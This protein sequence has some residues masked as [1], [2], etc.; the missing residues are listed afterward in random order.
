M[1][2]EYDA[3][4]FV[5][6]P[7]HERIQRRVNF[8]SVGVSPLDEI[9]EEIERFVPFHAFPFFEERRVSAAIQHMSRD[10]TYIDYGVGEP[11]RLN[12]CQIKIDRIFV[13]EALEIGRGIEP[14]QFRSLRFYFRFRI[15]L[16][17]LTSHGEQRA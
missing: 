2:A 13:V 3:G 8:Q 9:A 4:I 7:G 15:C 12:L 14:H 10:G 5:V 16:L 11:E 1:L 17:R 6:I